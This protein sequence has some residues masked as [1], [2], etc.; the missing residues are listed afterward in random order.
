MENNKL[1]AEFMGVKYPML[2]GSDLQYH[3][4]W[5]W[6]MPVIRKIEDG[7]LDPH[8][9]IDKAL[10]SRV[11]EDTYNEVVDTI[12]TYNDGSTRTS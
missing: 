10:E 2:K 12:K 5:D 11:I 3:T 1:I 9:L 8:E 4:S 7:G 6:L